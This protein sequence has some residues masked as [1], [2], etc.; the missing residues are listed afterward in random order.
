MLNNSS[1]LEFWEGH[2]SQA[3]EKLNL[4]LDFGWRSA[5]ALR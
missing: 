4:G 5:S 1:S 3:A 2:A